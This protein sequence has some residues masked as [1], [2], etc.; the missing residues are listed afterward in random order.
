MFI[1][2]HH[3]DHHDHHDHH[4]HH[5]QAARGQ[6]APRGVL[7]AGINLSNFLLVTGKDEQVIKLKLDD[8]DLGQH[9]GGMMMMTMVMMMMACTMWCAQGQHTG[10]SP[11]IA[12]SL[13]EALSVPLQLVP[14]PG[15]GGCF[16][17]QAGVPIES[18]L[19]SLRQACGRNR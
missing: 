9:M 16:K 12:K 2:R 14:F 17:V 3:D 18:K 15:P 11:G 4:H 5:H 13:A 8:D 6:L 19:F 1:D 10:V 7:R